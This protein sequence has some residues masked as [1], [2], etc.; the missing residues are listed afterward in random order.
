MNFKFIVDR[1]ELGVD[2][3]TWTCDWHMK[4]GGGQ[5]CGTKPLICGIDHEN[6]FEVKNTKLCAL[7]GIIYMFN[8]VCVYK[9]IKC[10]EKT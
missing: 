3:G 1:A 9:Q 10:I 8:Y 5:F 4:W 7:Y 6:I 2:I